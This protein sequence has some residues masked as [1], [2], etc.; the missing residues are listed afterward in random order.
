M[1]ILLSEKIF[2]QS[3]KILSDFR[4]GIVNLK[5][6]RHLKEKL[7][8]ELIPIALHTRRLWNFCMSEHEKKK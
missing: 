4:L 2:C 1:K 8:E 3:I 5:N 6:A 7:T